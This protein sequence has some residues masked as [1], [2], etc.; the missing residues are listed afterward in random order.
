MEYKFMQA[1]DLWFIEIGC[2]SGVANPWDHGLPPDL[3]R[4]IDERHS[5]IT[6]VT[7][8]RA[9]PLIPNRRLTYSA[10]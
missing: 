6:L 9:Q 3:R 8:L 10:Q 2:R 7:G 1:I 4:S 5:V